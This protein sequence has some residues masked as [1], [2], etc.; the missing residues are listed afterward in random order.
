MKNENEKTK[1][2]ETLEGVSKQEGAKMKQEKII[3]V[4][5]EEGAIIEISSRDTIVITYSEPAYMT[6]RDRYQIRINTRGQRYMITDHDRDDTR[7]I[8]DQDIIDD[9]IARV[10]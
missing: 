5:T 10:E 8:L 7:Y 4:K 1:T 9:F 6:D 3:R 2:A